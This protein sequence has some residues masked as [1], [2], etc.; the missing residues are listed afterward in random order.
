MRYITLPLLSPTLLFATI[1]GVI[2]AL[3]VFDEPYVMTRGG[4]GDASRTAVL[5]MYESA[6]KNQELGYGSTIIV[7]LFII[8]MLVTVIQFTFSKRWVFYQ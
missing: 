3:Q 2:G 7:L 5:V 6:F 1:T 8:I 4:P